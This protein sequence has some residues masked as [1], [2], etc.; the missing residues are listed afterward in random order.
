MNHTE[1]TSAQLKSLF[2]KQNRILKLVSS[3]KKG[4][5][6]ASG[7]VGPV[8][9]KNSLTPPHEDSPYIEKDVS[10]PVLDLNISV[11][12]K[13]KKLEDIGTFEH[14]E[15]SPSFEL[16]KEKEKEKE[17]RR[18]DDDLRSFILSSMDK[19][20]ENVPEKETK[21]SLP[22]G[23]GFMDSF[24]LSETPA[25]KQ[26]DPNSLISSI[27]S[28]DSVKDEINAESLREIL[29]GA[30]ELMEEI[31]I[32]I[33][34]A[35][36]W[37]PEE[38]R[39]LLRKV[40][41][42]KGDIGQAGAMRARAIVHHMENVLEDV[43]DGRVKIE[44]CRPDLFVFF[45]KLR[46][47][48]EE[49]RAGKWRVDQEVSEVSAVQAPKIVRV[50]ASSIDQMVSDVNEARLAC[51]SLQDFSLTSRNK[52][53][54]LEENAN[55]ASVM[56]RE[57]ELQSEI[58][59]QS[60]RTQLQEQG[61]DFD[62]LEFDRFTRLQEL[63]RLATESLADIYE[64]RRDLARN[65]AE[66]EAILAHQKRSISS[67]QQALHQTRLTPVDAIN[68][69]LHNVVRQ[70]SREEGKLVGFEM[71]GSRVELDRVLLEKII[72][73]LEHILRNSVVHGIERSEDRVASG[74]SPEGTI[75]FFVRQESD[76]VLLQI[77]DDGSGLR[78]DKIKEKAVEKG[79]WDSS[80]PMTDK[81]AAEIIC[82][83]GFSTAEHVSTLAGRGV[84]MDVVRNNILSL[85]GKFDVVSQ[86]GKGL[87]IFIQ[88]PTSVA[89]ASVLVV[90]AGGE[91]WA[92]PVE[93]VE[94]VL[95]FDEEVLAKYHKE[96]VLGESELLTP[97]SEPWKGHAFFALEDLTR[98]YSSNNLRSPSSPVLL[99][100]DRGQMMSLQ[101][102]R[103]V[104]VY[105][106]PLQPSGPLWSHVPG[107]AGTVI[108]P[109]SDA[110]FLVDPFR[111]APRL[112]QNKRVENVIKVTSP[113]VMVVD[114]S[115]TVRKATERFLQKNGFDSVMA[116]DGQDALDLLIHIRPHVILLDIEMPRMDGFDCAKNIREN[117][118]LSDI[119][120]IM[121]TSRTA[122][123]H[124][125]HAASLGVNEYL[126][127]PFKEDEL[128][129]LLKNYTKADKK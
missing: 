48:M 56:L 78:L 2:E 45:D 103:L 64:I 116:K 20:K 13:E 39:E 31:E 32:L 68:D 51:S 97:S 126:G 34:K 121:I 19:Q 73:P 1:K 35:S 76:R 89:S 115:L 127:K 57:L 63:S 46:S 111:F 71:Q 14:S 92:F 114:D 101:I 38:S 15:T 41:T 85:G 99:L 27:L 53:K 7:Q 26:D 72:P 107:V 23:W 110:V 91:S 25:V 18:D 43:K 82:S 119:P 100:R 98:V 6:Y 74:K 79:L 86:T 69:R 67:A 112:S 70:S 33:D 59:I 106:V 129:A 93:M 42:L 54:E 47:V 3:L 90:E 52:L 128:L 37:S 9:E 105:E 36:S 50:S 87:D 94:H 122:E 5:D 113:L 125:A 29:P 102:T 118:R 80:A 16:E 24:D 75:S 61:D 124:R 58:Q 84:G 65:L 66:Q 83:P 104:Q 96:G 109:N 21:P 44:D 123:K 120:I 28:G 11:P 95:L 12:E 8:P 55:R 17:N 40:H 117:P 49:L 4:L 77:K 22:T 81:D 88:L 60:R 10:L 62:P 108:L 30:D